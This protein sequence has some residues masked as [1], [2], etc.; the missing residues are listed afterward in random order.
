M[1]VWELNGAGKSQ[2][3]LNHMRAHL[4]QYRAVFWVEAGQREAGQRDFAQIY[5]L[6]FPSTGSSSAIITVE[7]AIRGVKSWLEGQEG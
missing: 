7:G 1:V 3:V 2:L 6:L 4:Q 5:K